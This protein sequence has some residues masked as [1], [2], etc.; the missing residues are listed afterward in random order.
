MKFTFKKTILI[1][2][3]TYILLVAG[4][5]IYKKLFG[6]EVVYLKINKVTELSG[7]NYFIRDILDESSYH[8]DLDFK[9]LKSNTDKI[10]EIYLNSYTKPDNLYKAN[11]L[12]CGYIEYVS[13]ASV[14]DLL[15]SFFGKNI[16]S[17]HNVELVNNLSEEEINEMFNQKSK[18]FLMNNIYI[19]LIFV[20][21]IVLGY[22]VNK[23]I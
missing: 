12:L 10:D 13:P 5:F 7:F 11:D 21:L 16:Y 2:L 20:A 8:Y 17:I 23:K 19:L 9:I 15:K 18:G 3:I 1:L 6:T 4:N 22:F 14:M